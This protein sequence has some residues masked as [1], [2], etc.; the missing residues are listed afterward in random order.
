M[1][2][3]AGVV[4][5][6]WKGAVR[7]LPRLENSDLAN[8]THPLRSILLSSPTKGWGPLNTMCPCSTFQC[9]VLLERRMCMT[10][11]KSFRN[12][13]LSTGLRFPD[14]AT[15]ARLS[16][17]ANAPRSAS[18]PRFWG[19]VCVLFACRHIG[20]LDCSSLCHES[21]GPSFRLQHLGYW[22]PLQDSRQQQPC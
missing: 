16:S 7:K 20:C 6:R 3:G 10:Y 9:E 21:S 4:S 2:W 1:A 14:M 5:V 18:Q 22:S 15:H 12:N 17:I 8:L 13:H 19:P 11:F